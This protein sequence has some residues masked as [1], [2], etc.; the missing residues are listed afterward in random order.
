MGGEALLLQCHTHI[1]SHLFPTDPKGSEFTH[2]HCG[3]CVNRIRPDALLISL[4][5]VVVS[6]LNEGTPFQQQISNT[7]TEN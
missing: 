2:H 5:I 4:I 3:I 7:T 6:H 1:A